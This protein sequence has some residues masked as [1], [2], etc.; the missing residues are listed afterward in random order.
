MGIVSLKSKRKYLRKRKSLK[1][2]EKRREKT[3]MKTFSKTVRSIPRLIAERA[4]LKK[5]ETTL[6]YLKLF[7][8]SM[9]E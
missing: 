4:R 6:K 7:P 9:S 1:L 8:M 3:I 2:V 5:M